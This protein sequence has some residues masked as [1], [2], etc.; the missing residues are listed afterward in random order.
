MVVINKNHSDSKTD[1]IYSIL[2]DILLDGVDYG[3]EDQEPI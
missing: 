2:D 1:E 3:N